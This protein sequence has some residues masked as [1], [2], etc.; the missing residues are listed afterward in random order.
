M[1]FNVDAGK[2]EA[3]GS[4][5]Y[6]YCDTFATMEEALAAYET[7]RD[8]PWAEISLQ[9]G[10]FVYALDVTRIRRKTTAIIGGEERPIFNPCDPDGNFTP[11]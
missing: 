10:D 9:D 3:D 8:Y 4:R 7:V 1:A 5:N 11:L 2:Y 6:K